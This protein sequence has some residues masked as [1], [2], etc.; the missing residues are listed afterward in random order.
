MSKNFWDKINDTL[1]VIGRLDVLVSS[2]TMLGIVSIAVWGVITRYILGQPAG[3]IGEL[4]L[5]LFIWLTFLGMSVLARRG[6]IVNIE[7][8]LQ[9][10]PDS[11][12][13]FIKR[14]VSTA[15]LVAC[16]SVIIYLG[17]KLSFFSYSRYTPSLRI[18]YTYV[19]LGIPVG[20]LFTL[21]EI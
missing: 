4:S 7:F 9:F 11:I 2:L 5:I 18:P 3:W 12:S 1:G 6:E 16:L 13:F 15:L 14:V 19:Y 17:F 10:F 20:S 8:L 21:Y